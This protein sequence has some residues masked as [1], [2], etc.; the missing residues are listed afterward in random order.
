M[1]VSCDK[2][3]VEFWVLFRSVRTDR[4]A[5]WVCKFAQVLTQIL[6]ESLL[7]YLRNAVFFV[8]VCG[9]LGIRSGKSVV[10]LATD[11]G[12]TFESKRSAEWNNSR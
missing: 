5:T 3:D 6:S 8:E 10:A 1:Y 4:D 9:D 12:L 11:E 2:I 7:K